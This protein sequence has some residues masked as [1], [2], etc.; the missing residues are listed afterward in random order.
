[1]SVEGAVDEYIALRFRATLAYD[2]TA[3]QG[4]QRQAGDTPTIQGAV[5]AAIAAVTGQKVTVNGA[6]RT[7]T[8]VHAE[9]QV[10]AFDVKWRHSDKALLRALNANLSDDIALQDIA[11]Q[12]GFHPRFNA[13][14]RLYRYEIV[15]AEHRQPL[16]RLRAW[17][18]HGA[19][20]TDA[21]E[22]AAALLIGEHDFAAFGQPPQGE[23]TTRTVL[24]SRWKSYPERFGT[25]LTYHIEANAFLQHMVRRI[26]GQLVEV[27]RG[28]QT[29]AQFEEA[30]LRAELI[31]GTPL[32]PPQGLVLEAVR[33]E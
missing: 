13:V 24:Q 26:V 4:F 22:R 17:R 19:L 1:M 9:G 31:G 32:A 16:L 33:Y 15:V 18:L 3:Y 10:I 21:M 20:S 30:F 14:A 29:A 25:R 6:G 27:G 8:G 2:G 11:Q 23:I 28:G 7:D 12:P 5:E